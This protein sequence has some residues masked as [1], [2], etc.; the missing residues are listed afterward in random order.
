MLM[1]ISP[2]KTMDFSPPKVA[3]FTTP[4]HMAQTWQLVERMRTM[5]DEDIKGLMKVSDKIAGLNR[6]RYADFDAATAL[7][8]TTKQAL[9]AFK[10]DTYKDMELDAW[11]AEDYAFA[12]RHLRILSG[13]YGQL[14]PLDLIKPYRLEMGTSLATDAGKNLYAFW[15]TSI[16][17]TLRSELAEMGS[18]AIVHL[19]SDEYFKSIARHLGNARVIQPAFLDYKNGAYKTISFFAKRARGSMAAW[20]IRRRITDPARLTQFDVGGYRY[21]SDAST[22]ERPVF[23]RRAT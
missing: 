9:L 4:R 21:V 8:S 3:D 5:S 17:E 19:A 16:A 20:A 18:E 12:Q 1:V 22:P 10:G 6:Q 11:N 13:L 2:A 7:D 14:R 23:H 15:G